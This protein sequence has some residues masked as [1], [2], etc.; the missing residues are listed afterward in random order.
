MF[1]IVDEEYQK[2]NPMEIPVYKDKNYFIYCVLQSQTFRGVKQQ[3]LTHTVH[4][5]LI[6]NS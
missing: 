4:L 6:I 1:I 2:K 3:P 5:V